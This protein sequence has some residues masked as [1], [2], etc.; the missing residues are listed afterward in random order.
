MNLRSGIEFSAFA[1]LALVLHMA[2]FGLTPP[3]EQAAADGGAGE[4][5]EDLTTLVAAPEAFAE[6]VA[7]FDAPPP[8]PRSAFR[9]DPPEMR[10]PVLEDASVPQAEPPKPDPKPEPKPEKTLAEPEPEPA[11]KAAPKKKPAPA[12]AKSASAKSASAKPASKASAGTAA[13]RAAGSGGGGQAGQG[14]AGAA[15]AAQGQ[16]ALASWG[17]SIRARIERR[18]SFPRGAGRAQG[19]VVVS[20]TVARSGQLVAVGIAKSSGN[21]ALDQAAVSAVQRAGR[22][23]AA[24]APL[25]KATYSFTLPVSFSRR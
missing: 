3:V 22:F 4:G 20:L 25:D 24:P 12:S 8:L 5:G 2:A 13:Q 17:A 16:N 10:L 11:P 9:I 18:K 1:A 15:S 7:R 21:P 6:M 19:N 23:P 14:G